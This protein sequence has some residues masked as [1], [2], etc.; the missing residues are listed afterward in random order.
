MLSVTFLVTGG[1][2]VVLACMVISLI[3][4]SR[5]DVHLPPGPTPLP[6]LGN[7]LVLVPTDKLAVYKRLRAE[8]GDIVCLTFGT[9]K[10]VIFSGYDLIREVF[11]KKGDATT[12]RPPQ[13][14]FIKSIQ[15]GYGVGGSSG[16]LWK[17]H[18]T[19]I[20]NFLRKSFRRE[21]LE[22][23]IEHEVTHYIK[24]IHDANE[25]PMELRRIIGTS[26][27]NVTLTLG[28]SKRFE[29]DDA[30]LIQLLK[31]IDDIMLYS[32]FSEALCFF[33]ALKYLPGDMFHAQSMLD[34]KEDIF[35]W[36]KE[37]IDERP[38][39]VPEHE[40]DIEDFIDAFMLE[41]KSQEGDTT[42]TE[43]QLL[44][45]LFEFFVAGVE[46]SGATIRWAVMFMLHNK[47][48]Q[49]KLADEI[50]SNLGYERTPTMA[51]H[52]HLNYCQ[53][54]I[55]EVQR[56]GNVAPLSGPHSASKDFYVNDYLIPKGATLLMNLTSALKDPK[57][58]DDP[59]AF[60]PERFLDSEGTYVV[61]NSLI[62]FSIGRR[63][64][65][66]KDL[67][68]IE[69]FL[70]ITS[71]VQNFEF[72]PE[73]PNT[74][75]EILGCDGISHGPVTFKFIAKRRRPVKM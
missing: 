3:L 61:Q 45:V 5:R 25:K 7:S 38:G 10:C 55:S 41:A 67:A 47:D 59:E 29:H 63:I 50:I 4:R 71:M 48:V 42:Y 26:L 51:D 69:L 53:A 12:N 65:L 66:G 70:F 21:R 9:T 39:G 46:T 31:A 24:R 49:D 28:M 27:T 57:Y 34:D 62:P 23:L 2:C 8:F 16:N 40:D 14:F 44:H 33:P 11:V 35:K 75:P 22:G 58:F 68:K 30:R 18:R 56:C 36:L 72:L 1:I 43:H 32:G 64:C 74:L 6:I 60:R 52:P 37:L 13:S 54:F 19:F 15:K 17:E 20:L 73:D